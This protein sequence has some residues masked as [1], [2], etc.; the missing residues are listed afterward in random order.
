MTRRMSEGWMKREY[1]YVT[2]FNGIWRDVTDTDQVTF[3]Y[4]R[5]ELDK[6]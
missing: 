2:C 4:K 1:I 6:T 3:Q 5:V